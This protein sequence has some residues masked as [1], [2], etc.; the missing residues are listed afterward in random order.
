MPLVIYSH[1]ITPGI[2]SP[3]PERIVIEIL[4]VIS[5][6]YVSIPIQL[7]V[8]PPPQLIKASGDGTAYVGFSE[9]GKLIP[10]VTQRL[11]C[12]VPT[13]FASPLTSVPAVEG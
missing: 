9:S 5:W 2:W 12:V 6:L 4:P 3:T 10:I 13:I 7:P 1:I 8:S 11:S